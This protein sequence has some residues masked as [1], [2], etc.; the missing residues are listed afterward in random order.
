MKSSTRPAIAG[1]QDR[2][3]MKHL[4]DR[5]L[6]TSGLSKAFGL[7]GLRIGWV[8]GPPRTIEAIWT[9]RDYTTIAPG[10]LSDHLA[11]IA[12]EPERRESIFRRTRSIIRRN[13]TVLE[14]WIRAHDALFTYTPPEA[15]A[16][17]FLRYNLPIASIPL[18]DRLRLDRSVL[19]VA[20]DQCGLSRHVRIGYGSDPD[21]L[22]RG[23][24]RIDLTLAELQGG[25]TATRRD[26][27]RGGD[28]R[29][30][31]TARHSARRSMTRR[32]G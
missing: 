2:N 6:I 14:G 32:A 30:N 31:S 15:G 12:M 18:V 3:P 5:V 8:I 4:Y 24:A 19:I 7:P 20:G 1:L 23:L 9:H 13:L 27:A 11:R 17:A 25:S 26:A 28:P 21:Y 16:I 29:P 22:L 10:I